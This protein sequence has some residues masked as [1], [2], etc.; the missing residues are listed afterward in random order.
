MKPKLKQLVLVGLILGSIF[1]QWNGE[2][3][4]IRGEELFED[5]WAL[6]S[7]VS[8]VIIEI[9]FILL[10]FRLEDSRNITENSEGL[11][12]CIVLH[13]LSGALSKYHDAIPLKERG[14][15][16]SPSLMPIILLL[17]SVV[18]KSSILKI[19]TV[20]FSMV[21]MF[22]SFCVTLGLS[23]EF[24]INRIDYLSFAAIFLTVLKLLCLK[25]FQDQNIKVRLRSNAVILCFTITVMCGPVLEF[26]DMSELGVFLLVS[27]TSGLFSILLLYLLYNYVLPKMAIYE[28]TILLIIC[29]LCHQMLQSE[30]FNFV[31][32][33]FGLSILIGCYAWRLHQHQTE[34]TQTPFKGK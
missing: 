30:H 18:C 26:L 19:D 2:K 17:C 31:S 25:Q 27:T 7:L 16:L 14:T 28:I 33:L 12:L 10:T 5:K 32:V 11:T 23:E 21:L 22:G 1:A 8:S 4:L 3:C 34:D 24:T 6:K 9:V 29:Y 13:L 20:I 15:D